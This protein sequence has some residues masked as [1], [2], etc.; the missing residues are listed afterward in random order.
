M[1]RLDRL[2]GLGGAQV[3][4]M[5]DDLAGRRIVDRDA[6]AVGGDPFA[7]DQGMLAEQGETGVT[8]MRH[9]GFLSLEAEK[10]QRPQPPLVSR[11]LS[12]RR[13]RNEADGD[14][15]R[16]R[17]A[18]SAIGASDAVSRGVSGEPSRML[19]IRKG[20]GARSDGA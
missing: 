15:L 9:G 20:P 5:A 2:I 16:I 17:R 6:G 11:F 19:Q 7:G 4:D 10:G 3:G 1:R 12:R 18:A 13:R 14:R 8:G